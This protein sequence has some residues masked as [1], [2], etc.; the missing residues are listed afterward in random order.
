MRA[1]QYAREKRQRER[2][3]W[4]EMVVG[5]VV[6]LGLC[7]DLSSETGV[8]KVKEAFEVLKLIAKAAGQELPSNRGGSDRLV[9][10]LDCAVIRQFHSIRSRAALDPVDTVRG[11]FI[12]GGPAY[13][14]SGFYEKTHVQICVCDPSAIKGVFRVLDPSPP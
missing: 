10:R 13:P 12:E 7:L 8:A 5:A 6:D 3:T 2:D 9:R 11:V 1:L 14:G 4:S